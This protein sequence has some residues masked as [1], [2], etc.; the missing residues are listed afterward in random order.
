[1]T[2]SLTLGV[3]TRA[4]TFT[5]SAPPGGDAASGNVRPLFWDPEAAVSAGPYVQLGRD[6]S[7]RW[8]LSG[9]INPGLALIDER[10]SQVSGYDFVPHVSAEAGVRREGARFSTAL[11]V[12][13]YQGQFDGYRTYGARLSVSAR[14][15]STLRGA[16]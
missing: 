10:R 15:L 5:R 1:M 16:R 6:L 11:D 13:Y 3:A 8:R 4:L 9:R 14:D 2:P 7:T 12:F